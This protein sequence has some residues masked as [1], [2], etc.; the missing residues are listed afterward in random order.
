MLNQN[1]K[2]MQHRNTRRRLVEHERQEKVRE[3]WRA[4]RHVARSM[5]ENI[6]SWKKMGRDNFLKN[7]ES[8]LKGLLSLNSTRK[9]KALA[10]F[11]CQ[12]AFMKRT[13]NIDYGIQHLA[14]CGPV[15]S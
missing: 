3:G 10:L 14:L 11:Q 8:T 1:H 2:R 15:V 5:Q 4:L 9:H 7:Y 13:G 12:A 6:G